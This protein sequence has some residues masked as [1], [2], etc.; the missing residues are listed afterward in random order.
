M[1][2]PLLLLHEIH[3]R[4]SSTVDAL[5]SNCSS[6]AT[7]ISGADPLEDKKVWLRVVVATVSFL[8]MVGALLIILSYVCISSI[9]TRSREILVH[10]SVADFGVA[11]AN[12]IGVVVDFDHLIRTCSETSDH[13]WCDDV[14][15]LCTA[16][17]FFAGFSTIASILWTL[18]L[19]VYIYLLVVHE[20][21]RLHTKA[22]YFFY[23]FCWGM[24]LLISLWLVLTGEQKISVELCY[25]A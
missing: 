11:C 14:H 12:F 15:H 10:L 22:V 17:A 24:P 5:V 6:N 23:L 1:S 19:S 7:T 8:S 9:R 3:T 21:H 2:V 4:S 18:A 16:Q 13:H 25:K 20:H